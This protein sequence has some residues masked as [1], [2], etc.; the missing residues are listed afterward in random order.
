MF[1]SVGVDTESTLLEIF[2]RGSTTY[3]NSSLFFPPK[4]RKEVTR[5]YAF[6]RVADDYVD[7]VPQQVDKFYQFVEEFYR[8]RREGRSSNVVIDSF[9][10]LEREKRFEEDWADSFLRSMEMDIY[11]KR[12]STLDELEDYMYGSAEVIGLMMAKILGLTDESH[13][14]ARL[15]G[16]SM[17][18]VN[19]LRDVKEDLALGRQ[20]IPTAVLERFGISSLE[21]EV[22]RRHVKEF[23][24]AMRHMVDVYFKWVKG[25]E[26]GFRFIPHR[27]LVPIKTANDMYKWT[28]KVI[29]E[30]PL[31]VYSVKV[32]PRKSK[33]VTRALENIIGVSIWKYFLNTSPIRK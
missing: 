31:V 24:G 21:E 11:K 12:Y 13:P 30:S 8:A 17:Q 19:F 5:L 26:R 22:V 1:R 6:V 27:Y 25:A 9:I 32:K 14:H 10:K 16:K 33:I 3:F 20:Y 28:A 29:N 2:K 7:S 23:E 18:L 15:L 4:V